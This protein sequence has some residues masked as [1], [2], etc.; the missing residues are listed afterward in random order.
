[1]RFVSFVGVALV[2]A[3]AGGTAGIGGCGGGT[4]PPAPP[5]AALP[6]DVL[7]LPSSSAGAVE[8]AGAAPAPSAPPSAR[9]PGTAVTVL[10]KGLHA[11]S[12]LMLDRQS[13]YWVDAIDGDLSRIPK[14]GGVTMVVYAGTGAAFTAHSSAAVDDTDVYLASQIDR[15]STL[16]RQDK[17]GGKPT[18]LAS[19]GFAPI[20]GVAL[21]D[22]DVY[23]ALGGGILRASKSGGAP[24]ALAG[25]FQGTSGVAVD[26][27]HV[28]WS[29]RGT[30][31]AGFADGAIVESA[32]GGGNARVL[33]HG[34]AGAENVVL[35][36]S[37]VYWRSGSKVFKASKAKGDAVQLAEA[38]GPVGDI[39]VDDVY[40]YFLTPDAVARVPKEGGRSETY[41]DAP[42]TP[43]SIAVDG[44]S[45]YFTTRGTESGKWRDGTLAKMEK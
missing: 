35:D 23:W 33:V 31:A 4:P 34:A 12:A 29:V 17:N 15:T 24:R 18:V 27:A 10:V 1:M 41:A 21:D 44:T 25:G 37:T 6:A 36:A 42:G 39:A 8:D 13:V 28:Y 11:P 30:E 45:V 7:A 32:K 26:G 16:I 38:S 3:F 22:K 5:P 20:E 14:R 2:I 9:P 40:A 43:T 19:S